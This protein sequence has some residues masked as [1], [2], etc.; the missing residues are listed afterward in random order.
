MAKNLSAKAAAA[1]AAGADPK[2][3]LGDPETPE[4]PNSSPTDPA[5]DETPP[6]SDQPPTESAGGEPSQSDAPAASASN[7]LADYLKL[8]LAEV[9]TKM[10]EMTAENTSLKAKLAGFEATQP[11]MRA[12]VEKAV[13][14]MKVAL[15][16]SAMDM[17]AFPPEALLQLHQVTMADFQKTFPVGGVSQLPDDKPQ[18]SNTGA[19]AHRIHAVRIGR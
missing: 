9:N 11:Q 6:V 4:T 12:I 19:G 2:L 15:G 18:D 14:G 1:L 16:G 17:T 13:N 3:I 8:Q 7:E 10:A 5:G